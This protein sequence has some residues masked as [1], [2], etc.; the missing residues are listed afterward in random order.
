MH[1]TAGSLE[2]PLPPSCPPSWKLQPPSD[3]WQSQLVQ[4][5][6]GGASLPINRA[7]QKKVPDRTHPEHSQTPKAKG[8]DPLWGEEGGKLALDQ[9]WEGRDGS[10]AGLGIGPRVPTSPC[11]PSMWHSPTCRHEEKIGFQPQIHICLMEEIQKSSPPVERSHMTPWW[12]HQNCTW[13]WGQGV[14]NQ[15]H[16]EAWTGT[17]RAR[18]VLPLHLLKK[19]NLQHQIQGTLSS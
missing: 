16:H 15:P 7:V 17:P 3:T 5:G 12:Q 14:Q 19:E 10:P 4:G 6:G 13:G 9:R 8:L 11:T 1:R 18:L 2:H